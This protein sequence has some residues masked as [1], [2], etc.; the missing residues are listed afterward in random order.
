[1]TPQAARAA[2]WRKGELSFKLHKAQL[3][4]RDA[5]FNVKS[6][7]LKFI[8]N[9]SRQLGKSYFLCALAIEFALKNPD[10]QIK[11]A[12]PTQRMVKQIIRPHF[13]TLLKDC[14][15]D[16]RPEWFAQESR[17]VFKNGSQ[18]DIAGAEAG[19]ADRLRGTRMHL[20]IVD[21]AGFCSDLAYLVQDVMLP[22][23]LTTNGRIIL[24]ST[25]PKTPMHPFE[26]YWEQALKG[27]SCIRK[28]IFDNPLLSEKK[29]KQYMRECGGDHTTAWK[30]EY[31]AEFI[32]DKE[33]IV[34][35]EF[36]DVQQDVVKEIE[37]PKYFDA[38]VSLDPGYRDLTVA[39]FGYWDF[40]NAS[41]VIE[42][43]FILSKTRTDILAD[44]I[45][46]K[47]RLLWN[48]QKPYFRVSDTELILIQDLSD[49]H[50]LQFH[51]TDKDN[52]LAQINE[53][54]VMVQAKRIIIHPRCKELI[55]HLRNAVWDDTTKDTFARIEGFGHFDAVD[56][57]VYM[58][59]NVRRNHNPFPVGKAYSHET[60]FIAY[61]TN[62]RSQTAKVIERL[63]SS[64]LKTRK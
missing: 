39:L 62:E 11:Y 44:G 7:E 14:P 1:M 61:E 47:E 57:L 18:I 36:L 63:F 48:G 40:L 28:T 46:D 43:E 51:P 32:I 58:L 13:R 33:S 60:H 45:K 21:E 54:R 6:D 2:L 8:I 64:P 12:A 35:P 53:L 10:A 31:L 30:R 50:G 16:I 49:L 19:N 52:K 55:S 9:C 42:D 20:G 5:F 4:M 22:M 29:I 41:L 23:T 15:D 56:A 3:E 26:K 59:R 24:A 25:P 17:Y 27:G 37:R 38:Y 34:V